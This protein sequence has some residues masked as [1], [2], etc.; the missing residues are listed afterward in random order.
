MDRRIAH[1]DMD[2]FYA[3]VELQRY[4]QL[5]GQPLVVGGR[6]QEGPV[7]QGSKLIFRGFAP[8]RDV[9]WSPPRPT[10][11]APLACIPAW[12]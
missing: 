5:W 8:T 1:L 4:P 11:H 7:E 6:R 3:S 10:R 12:D 2:A 9:A